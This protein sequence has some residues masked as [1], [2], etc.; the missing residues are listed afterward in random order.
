MKARRFRRR[1]SGWIW[2]VLALTSLL[3]FRWAWYE[4]W[5]GATEPLPLAEGNYRV[6]RIV[7]GDTIV[8]ARH[9]NDSSAGPAG[10]TLR[11]LGIDCPETVKP[12]HAVEPWGKEASALARQMLSEQVVRLEFDK[13]RVDIYGRLLAYVYVRETLVNE[14]LVRQGLARVSFLGGD[15]VVMRK[16]FQAAQD[17]ARAAGRG[18]W[19][20]RE[21]PFSAK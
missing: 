1:V 20:V 11:L 6:L 9:A 2:V 10:A 21:D 19:S 16:R 13:R 17:E 5:P 3:V 12:H 7:D 18:I 8:V 4:W 14:E 15:S